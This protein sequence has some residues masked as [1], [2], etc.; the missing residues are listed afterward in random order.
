MEEAFGNLTKVNSLMVAA[1]FQENICFISSEMRGV[2][3]QSSEVW[4]ELRYGRITASKIYDVIHSKKSEGTA[5]ESILGA[6]KVSDAPALQRGRT[7]EIRVL[8]E[9]EKQIKTKILKCG[10][11]LCIDYPYLNATPD[12]ITEECMVEVRS[13][14]I[15]KLEILVVSI[16]SCLESFSL[17]TTLGGLIN[18]HPSAVNKSST[19]LKPL[20]TITDASGGST[21]N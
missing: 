11:L 5:V 10:I 6:Y 12:G 3:T 21:F 7:L 9:A 18:L 13:M 1:F 17:F 15:R 2:K 8:E 16:T 19:C 4:R 14:W 20:S